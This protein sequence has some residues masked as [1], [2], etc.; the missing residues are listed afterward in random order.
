MK[1]SQV[2]PD[3]ELQFLQSRLFLSEA[4][5]TRDA[6]LSGGLEA[7]MEYSTAVQEATTEELQPADGEETVAKDAE[8]ARAVTVAWEQLE[9]RLTL[10]NLEAVSALDVPG[11]ATRGTCQALMILLGKETEL[12]EEWSQVRGVLVEAD[13]EAPAEPAEGEEPAEDTRTLALIPALRAFT[14]DVTVERSEE[15][16][17]HLAYYLDTVKWAEKGR[18]GK[19]SEGDLTLQGG[20]IACHAL[21]QWMAATQELRKIRAKIKADAPPAAEEEPAAEEPPAE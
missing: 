2:S 16:E 5:A 13:G 19:V 4:K 15:A 12:T 21:Y 8:A 6:T 7:A 9:P 3:E 14:E 17:T 11:A 20:T 10:P 18:V 1:H